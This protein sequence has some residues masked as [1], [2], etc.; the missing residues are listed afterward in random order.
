MCASLDD[1]VV[2]SR[3]ADDGGAIRRR[4]E[5]LGCGRRYTTFE[6]VEET[7]LV[8]VKRSGEREPF[9]L[10]KLVAG[11]GAAAKNRLT[12]AQVAALAA[13]VED[14]ARLAGPEFTTQE[15]G[16]AVLERLGQL[17]HVTYLR[18]ASVYKGFEDLGDFEREV[19][20]LTKATPPKQR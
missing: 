14:T 19:G 18:Y 11:V 20:L 4:R 12:D 17:D 8:V 10:Q 3:Q 15:I 13:E 5:C 2:D 7:P 9:D 6:R 16:I 1:K